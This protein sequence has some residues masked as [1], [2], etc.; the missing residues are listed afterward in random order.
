MTSLLLVGQ[1]EGV[2]ALKTATLLSSLP[3]TLLMIVFCVAVFKLLRSI[4][5]GTIF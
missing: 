5:G 3:H 1:K 4:A 2:K